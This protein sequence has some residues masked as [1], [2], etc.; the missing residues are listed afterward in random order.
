VLSRKKKQMFQQKHLLYFPCTE[1]RAVSQE[2]AADS[3]Y[4]FSR[5]S[6]I[7][8]QHL[9]RPSTAGGEIGFQQQPDY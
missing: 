9:Y 2:L 6:S 3:F 7:P 4:D 1:F 8:W 5:T